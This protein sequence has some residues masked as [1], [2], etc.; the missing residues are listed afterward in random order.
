MSM[1]FSQDTINEIA[2]C[3]ESVIARFIPNVEQDQCATGHANGEPS[4]IDECVCFMPC[5]IADSDV[6][7]AFE[8]GPLGPLMGMKCGGWVEVGIRLT[9]VLYFVF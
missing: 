8:H 9:T 7:I 4:D 1:C 6:E 5:E 3:V 2:L